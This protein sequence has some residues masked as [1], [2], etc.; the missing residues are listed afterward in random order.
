MCYAPYACVKL[1]VLG[2]LG[3]RHADPLVAARLS[4]FD[5]VVQGRAVFMLLWYVGL[6]FMAAQMLLA[7]SLLLALSSQEGSKGEARDKKLH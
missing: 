3:G 1:V 6:A 2:R 5:I 4:Y 7:A